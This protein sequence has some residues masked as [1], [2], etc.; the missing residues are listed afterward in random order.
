[1]VWHGVHTMT[2]VVLPGAPSYTHYRRDR[3][4]VQTASPQPRL[5]LCHD[6]DERSLLEMV[7]GN[8]SSSGSSPSLRIVFRVRLGG[9]S[10]VVSRQPPCCNLRN[11]LVL[12]MHGRSNQ[13]FIYFYG[14]ARPGPSVSGSLPR[15]R[16][17]IVPQSHPRARST[18]GMLQHTSHTPAARW[19]R[20][21][22]Y[23][24]ACIGGW[25]FDSRVR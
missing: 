21:T 2:A 16:T 24:R 12:C 18:V 4:T 11:S 19:D 6:L 3:F 1:M 9:A 13:L 25:H 5:L 22:F 17:S 7:L 15:R 23:T 14:F 10:T 20:W 8:R